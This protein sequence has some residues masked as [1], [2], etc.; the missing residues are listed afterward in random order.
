MEEYDCLQNRIAHK[1]LTRGGAEGAGIALSV[2]PPVKSATT[3]LTAPPAAPAPDWTADWTSEATTEASEAKA[4]VTVL[5]TE[6]ATLVMLETTEL[7]SEASEGRREVVED[8]A[9][10]LLEV[11]L[12]EGQSL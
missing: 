6:A 10:V 8:D 7:A 4:A 11:V 1:S 5:T 2:S 3:L 12:A 9:V